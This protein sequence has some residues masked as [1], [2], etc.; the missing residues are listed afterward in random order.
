MT[1]RAI[2]I[3]RRAQIVKRWRH[4]ADGSRLV[5]HTRQI[6]V[7]FQ[8]HEA[9]FCPSQHARIR[10][11]MHFVTRGAALEPYG[12]VLEREGSAFVAMALEAT[13]LVRG[14]DLGH[15]RTNAAVWIVAIHASHCALRQ[16]VM[17]GSLK[18]RPDVGMAARTLLV[19]SRGRSHHKPVRAVRVDLMTGDAGDLIFR[20]AALQAADVRRLI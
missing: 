4:D 8:T 3:D 6:G 11:A 2:L 16:L 15:R 19:H 18:L 14:E 7:T 9:N 1:Y 20:V 12:R 17:I 13:G 5:I 10:R